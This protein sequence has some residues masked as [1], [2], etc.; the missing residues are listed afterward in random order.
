MCTARRFTCVCGAVSLTDPV[1]VVQGALNAPNTAGNLYGLIRKPPDERLMRN[2]QRSHACTRTSLSLRPTILA[3]DTVT[4][5]A[6]A[7]PTQQ[8]SS[9]TSGS[10]T[11][12]REPLHACKSSENHCRQLLKLTYM[13][14]CDQA[15]VVTVLPEPLA[16]SLAP[17]PVCNGRA[18]RP[19][20]M[21][22][23]GV[24]KDKGG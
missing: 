1:L 17:Q 20:L 22:T 3:V 19:A 9:S 12:N 23:T 14:A 13:A 11:A 16:R 15:L 18:R 10:V 5:F 4:V 7:A 8:H 6:A 24:L 2:I 21:A